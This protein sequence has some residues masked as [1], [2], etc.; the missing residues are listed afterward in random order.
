MRRSRI[1]VGLS[2]TAATLA[3]VT[4]C[5]TE[6]AGDPGAQPSPSTPSSS[7][8]TPAPSTPA[9]PHGTPSTDC[10]QP[11]KAVQ[12]DLEKATW[13]EGM[14]KARFDPVTVTICQYDAGAAGNAYATE[15]TKRTQTAS[16]QL[17]TLVNA[18]DPAKTKPGI[19]TKELG[20]TYVLRFTDIERGVLTY[21][22]EAF[23]CRRLVA[24][25][26]VGD[27]KPLGLAAPRQVTPQLLKSL[28]MG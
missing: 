13:G 4:A 8:S 24:T 17:F 2:T 27:G 11:I 3:A 19:C 26:F 25:S 28:G 12:Q 16:V 1:T 5:G 21:V 7:A 22:A 18:A 23:G 20:P 15:Q 14:A 6:S 10:P 9:S